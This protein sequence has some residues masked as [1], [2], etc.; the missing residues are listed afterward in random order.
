MAEWA[1]LPEPPQMGL[2][3]EIS[4]FMNEYA[5]KTDA[6]YKEFTEERYEEYV[7][8]F[9]AGDMVFI[10]PSGNPMDMSGFKGMWA[11]GA[12]KDASS[13]LVSVDSSR[14]LGVFSCWPKA[15]PVPPGATAVITY[16]THDKFTFQGNVNDDIAKFTAVLEK[17]AGWKI[18]HAHRAT[19]QPPK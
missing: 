1:K 10:R 19:G 5:T 7:E 4:L 17:G 6:I 14:L 9:M 12:I 13:E 15:L 2:G 11:S 8:K 3:H 18:V 16:T